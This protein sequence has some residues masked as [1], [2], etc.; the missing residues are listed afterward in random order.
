MENLS[1]YMDHLRD[2][3]MKQYNDTL[4]EIFSSPRQGSRGWGH[5]TGDHGSVACNV[6]SAQRGAR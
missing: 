6:R 2:N 3:M 5:T 1:A 4:S